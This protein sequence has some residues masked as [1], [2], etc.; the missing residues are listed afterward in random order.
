MS[1]YC[2]KSDVEP[3]IKFI[4]DDASTDLYTSVLDNADAWVD[5]R[6]LSNSLSI[7]T[8]TTLT[9]TVE[10]NGE[11]QTITTDTISPDTPIPNLLKTAAKYYAASDIILALYNGEDLPSQF[12]TYFQK[13]ETMIDAYIT[14]QKDLLADSELRNKNLVKHSKSLSYNQ[15]RRR[16]ML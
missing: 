6:L 2:T 1:V 3:L 16:P 14:Q 12:D 5:A 13:A 15:K 8:S 9:E 7:W 11:P 4:D 10:T